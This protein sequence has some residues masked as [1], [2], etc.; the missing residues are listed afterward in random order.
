MEPKIIREIGNL[1]ELETSDKSSLVNAVNENKN[2]IDN[3]DL[4]AEKVTLDSPNF[5]STNVRDGMNE[6][7]TNVSN[8]KNAIASAIADMGQ[9]ASGSDTFNQLSTKIK[10]I[11]KDANA[12]VGQV[13][14]GQ[15]FYQGGVKRTGNM[16]NRGAVTNTIATQNGSYTIPAGY[17][18]G[19]GKVT[20]TFSNLTA[21][22]VR[23]GVNIGGVIG[24]Y[25][26][27]NIENIQHGVASFGYRETNVDV[28]ISS[29]DTSRSIVLVSSISA[30]SSPAYSM[31]TGYLT[32]ATNLRLN[33]ASNSSYSGPETTVNWT[34]ITFTN[35]TVQR[36][37]LNLTSQSSNVTIS[38]VNLNKSFAVCSYRAVITSSGIQNDI[39][40]YQSVVRLSSS[41]NLEVSRLDSSSQYYPYVYWHVVEFN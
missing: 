10:D 14:N 20:A 38:S 40:A 31:F 2:K 32:T 12:T 30:G 18:N 8:G 3:I 7:F 4:S 36:G 41:T 27:E 6:L 28:T 19:S 15:T 16:P 5:T 1:S 13:L 17:H 23:S 37:G 24:N 11:S 35:A 39:D 26:G 29:S 25:V 22:N 33:R 21:G 9:S 34:V